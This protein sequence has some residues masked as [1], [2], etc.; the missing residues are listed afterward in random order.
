[1]GEERKVRVS[2]QLTLREEWLFVEE[3]DDVGVS[4]LPAEG[5]QGALATV[6]LDCLGE[7]IV[8]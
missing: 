7:M 8:E 3:E 4:A 5:L 1:M 2:A 6:V